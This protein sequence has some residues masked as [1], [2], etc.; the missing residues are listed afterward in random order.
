MTGKDDPPLVERVAKLEVE[1]RWLKKLAIPN[2]V[3][4]AATFLSVILLL[5]VV[6]GL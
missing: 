3:F 1:V 5:K 4:Q 2:I 6:L